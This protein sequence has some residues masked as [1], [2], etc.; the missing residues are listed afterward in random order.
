M[1]FEGQILKLLVPATRTVVAVFAA[2]IWMAFM[3]TYSFADWV[4]AD[5]SG[6]VNAYITNPPQ[7]ITIAA[8]ALCITTFVIGWRRV[9]PGMACYLAI[10]LPYG[11]F[12]QEYRETDLLE[13]VVFTILCC[14]CFGWLIKKT[15]WLLGKIKK[16][17]VRQE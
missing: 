4:N 9:V 12:V 3:P 11:F 2:L 14:F 10:K 8:L 6:S 7:L 17:Q 16:K 1:S 5:V 13:V 15:G